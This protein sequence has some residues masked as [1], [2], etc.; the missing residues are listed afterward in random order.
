MLNW[1][2]VVRTLAPDTPAWAVFGLAPVGLLAVTYFVSL[3]VLWSGWRMFLP[4]ERTPFVPVSG[5]AVEHVLTRS[6]RDSGAVLDATSGPMSGDPYTVPAPSR[7]F[8]CEV[9]ADPGPS[10]DLEPL[11]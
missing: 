6:V 1:L 5:W 2:S 4:S 11:E 10:P 8:L 9:D 7:P 3:F